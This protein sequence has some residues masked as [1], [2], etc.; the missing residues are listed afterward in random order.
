M[1]SSHF[2]TETPGHQ[3]QH[4][5]N[6]LRPPLTLARNFIYFKD[7][8]VVEPPLFSSRDALTFTFRLNEL[9]NFFQKNARDQGR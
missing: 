3:N 8:N 4:V 7:K 5:S 6:V 9:T 1:E 2:H